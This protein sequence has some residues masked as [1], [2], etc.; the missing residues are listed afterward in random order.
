[1]DRYRQLER[2]HR[3]ARVE[4]DAAYE[5]WQQAREEYKTAAIGLE[6][7]T[8]GLPPGSVR[9]DANGRAVRTV[10]RQVRTPLER[11]GLRVVDTSFVQAEERLPS[12]DDVTMRL[13]EA[14]QEHDRAREAMQAAGHKA[15]LYRRVVEEAAGALSR[16]GGRVIAPAPSSIAVPD[17]EGRP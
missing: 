11:M 8:A 10:E 16:A 17:A 2:L 15:G 14:Q 9:P 12:F 3:T 5:A 1:M 6:R 13:H 7:A 4:S